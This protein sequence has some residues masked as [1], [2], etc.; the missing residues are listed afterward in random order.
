MARQHAHGA[1]WHPRE[2]R[3]PPLTPPGKIRPAP[4]HRGSRSGPRLSPTSGASG[5]HPRSPAPSGDVTE[6]ALRSSPRVRQLP[7]AQDLGLE[8]RGYD[9]DE[10]QARSTILGV[11]G[12]SSSVKFSGGS[13]AVGSMVRL[14]TQRLDYNGNAPRHVGTYRVGQ[15]NGDRRLTTG[16]HRRVAACKASNL[17]RRIRR[18]GR[19]LLEQEVHRRRPQGSRHHQPRGRERVHRSVRT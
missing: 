9:Y 12:G 7:G 17:D 3:D 18:D 19:I 13:V 8:Q 4:W 2:Q 6:V 1:P 16:E 5:P 10:V 15:L 14:K 11:G